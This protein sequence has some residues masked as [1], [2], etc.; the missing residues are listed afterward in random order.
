MQ[1]GFSPGPVFILFWET[2]TGFAQPPLAY[3]VYYGEQRFFRVDML[4]PRI[5]PV[6][7]NSFLPEYAHIPVCAE[8]V[9]GP[10]G[11]LRAGILQPPALAVLRGDIAA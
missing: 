8:D 5:P 3:Q 2:G 1:F 10:E 4:T 7:V 9:I 11:A 6:S